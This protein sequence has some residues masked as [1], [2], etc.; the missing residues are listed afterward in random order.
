M[1][2]SFLLLITIRLSLTAS[3]L[4]DDNVRAVQMKL[5][6]DGFYS[7]KV[8]GVPSSELSTAV[9]RYQIRNGLQITGKLD[10]QT[11]RALG[12]KA[13]A[14]ETTAPAAPTSET[15]RTLRKAERGST[16][17]L[18]QERLRDYIGAFV[19][20]GLDSQV[21]AELEFFGDRVRYYNEGLIGREAIRRDLLRYDA[22][23]P[24]RRFWL[25]GKINIEPQAD[26]RIRVTFPLRY[27]LR[28]GP[29]HSSGMITK[30]L[31]LEVLG[32]D[33]LQIVS[34]NESKAH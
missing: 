26:S 19:L 14:N 1:K 6:A 28:R 16:F 7:G 21:G 34:V 20:A 30:E 33:D 2:R 29:K 5:K 9:T 23:W 32:P 11:S 13:E 12:V 4:A 22:H 25:A 10:E 24:E 31:L 17:V 3:I 27:E 15:W 8:D 18:S